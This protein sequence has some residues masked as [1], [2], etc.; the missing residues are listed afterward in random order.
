MGFLLKTAA[1]KVVKTFC[2][3]KIFQPLRWH[4]F[5]F[6]KWRFSLWKRVSTNTLFHCL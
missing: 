3:K 5:F 1:D 2:Q 4:Y 6:L